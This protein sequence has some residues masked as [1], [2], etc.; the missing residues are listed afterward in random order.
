VFKLKNIDE[1]REIF[2]NDRFATVNGAYIEEVGDGYSVC[3]IEINEN[4]KNA[5]GGVMGGVPF[6][7]ADFAFAV[8][9]NHETMNTV[10]LSSTISFLG[11][12]KGNRLI[13]KAECVKFGR[14][15]CY[16]TVHIT[17][18]IGT[19]V[20]EVVFTGFNKN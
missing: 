15:T 4:H 20:A 7:L 3:S 19:K 5:A 6:M 8:A 14:A 9:V 2:K 12:A 11:V 17:D 18:E 10:S 13:A 16:Y 1:I